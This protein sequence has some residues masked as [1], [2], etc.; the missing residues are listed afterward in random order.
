MTTATEM[1]NRILSRA[2]EDGAFRAHL[3]ADP[4]TTIATEIGTTMPEGFEVIVHEDTATT[5]HL[6]LPPSPQL[7]EAEMERVA[8]GQVEWSYA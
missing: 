2:A 5:T 6:V 7:T 4:K 3:L 1:R 8:G